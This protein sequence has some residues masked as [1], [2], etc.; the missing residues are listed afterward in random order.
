MRYFGHV[1]LGRG[2]EA[3]A[4]QA[5]EVISLGWL[6][7]ASLSPGGAGDWVERVLDISPE[8]AAPMTQTN[9]SNRR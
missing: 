9:I 2:P 1:T 5:G 7:N 6:G 4:G 3:E 8:N